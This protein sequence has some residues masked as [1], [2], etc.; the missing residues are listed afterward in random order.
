[1]KYVDI[2][3]PVYCEKERVK[4]AID[5]IVSQTFQNWRLIICDDGSTDGTFEVIKEYEL[6]YPKKIIVLRNEKNKGIVFTLNRML[7]KCNSEYVARMDADDIS[8]SERLEI[9]FNFLNEHSE[10]AMVG[11]SIYKFDEN[12]IF[13][14]VE[15]PESPKKTDFLWNNPFVHSTIMIR[16]N[17]LE[18]IGKYIDIP[19]TK[20]CED[21]DLWMRLYQ[22]G[23]KGQNIQKPLL[24]YYEGRD[25]YKKRK[26]KYRISEART[27][28][29]GFKQLHLLPKG[30][31]YAIKPFVVG[32]IPINIVKRIKK[33][34]NKKKD[35]K[36]I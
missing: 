21:Y 36:R 15:Y 22:F 8:V 18:K 17:V 25:A 13:A 11:S 19:R 7:E 27:R 30:L 1:M 5:S 33:Y 4:T 24:L 29:Y 2:I 28:L 6:A 31:I 16:R 23:Y 32:I 10:L 26:M 34:R 14:T 20:R 12:G 3:M 9:Q 35:V